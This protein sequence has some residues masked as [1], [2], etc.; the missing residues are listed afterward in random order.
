VPNVHCIIDEAGGLGRMECLKDV[1]NVGRGFGLKLQL[2]YQ[3]TGQLNTCWENP[4]GVL[5]NTTK[6]FAA[7][8]HLETA[9]ILSKSLGPQ[10]I[11]VESGGNNSGW[12]WNQ[13]TSSG[14]GHSQS[15]GSSYS[16]GSNA[17]WQQSGRDLAQAAEILALDPR[18]A[19][20]LTP[21]VR[22]LWTKLIRYYEEKSLLQHR[23]WL[24]RLADACR[25]FVISAV[26]LTIA[27]AAAKAVTG[28]LADYLEQPPPPQQQQQPQQQ[29]M[30]AGGQ[31]VPW[32][33]PGN[34]RR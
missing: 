21:G 32:P 13:S 12:S 11:V 17:N 7:T 28:E 18:I 24:R 5:A 4:A 19:I 10:T 20:T 1:L 14:Q 33:A 9:E 29:W 22:P 23:G 8:Q 31:P 27:A 26:L 30:P 16:T 15:T 25:T 3:D 34:Y 2:Y 6:I